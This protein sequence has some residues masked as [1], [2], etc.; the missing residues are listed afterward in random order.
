MTGLTGA[1]TDYV[2][3]TDSAS[4][5]THDSRTKRRWR[6]SAPTVWLWMAAAVVLLVLWFAF[7]EKRALWDPDE[8]RYAEIPR[9]MVA[10]G[11]WLT[12]RLNDL[13]YFEKPPLQYWA[14]AVAYELMGQHNWTARLWSALTGLAGVLLVFYAGRR[15]H[16]TRAGLYSAAMLASSLLYFGLAHLNSL[17]TGLTFFL[18]LAVCALAL[19]LNDDATAVERRTWIAVAW[20][21]AGLAVL[22][23]GLIGIVLPAGALMSYAV[24]CR[25]HAVW[26]KLSPLS[27]T[28]LLLLVT[29]PWFVAI[30]RVHPE[31]TQFFFVHEHFTRFTTTEHHR[32]QPWWFFVPVLALGALPWTVPMLC[33]LWRAFTE[34][35]EG[36]FAPFRFLAV[37]TVLVFVFFS[38]S[39]SKLVP[40]VLPAFPALA[41]LGGRY[42]CAANP[43][44]L[45]RQLFWSGL[46]AG[47]LLA[48]IPYAVSRVGA[49]VESGTIGELKLWC[50]WLA[51]LWAAGAVLSLWAMRKGKV[52]GA[53]VGF[54]LTVILA[55]QIALA[56]AEKLVPAKSSTLL[57]QQIRPYVSESTHIYTIQVYPQSLPFYL[58]RTVTLVDFRDELDF[59]LMRAPDKGIPSVAAFLEQ[60]R[61][62]R[63]AIAI[64]TK[65]RYDA[66]ASAGVPMMPIGQNAAIIAVRRP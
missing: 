14:T 21:A 28:V 61:N 7:L 2:M 58:G 4:A 22:S 48:V 45:A 47:L 35:R 36:A 1:H 20:L 32:G 53:I 42:V 19:G 56:G 44:S 64:M 16:S 55:H 50:M 25:D 46:A 27:G 38:A 34:R 51:G 6:N 23:K 37:W 24:L 43:V 52:E 60:W 30:A 5:A 26:R 41:L 66:L 65:T 15:L 33:G 11:D 10:S 63:D 18:S 54:A 39:G 9:E 40:Y 17:D 29:A 8:G 49:A 57:A 13:L 31:F 59:G 12:P 62:E 3:S